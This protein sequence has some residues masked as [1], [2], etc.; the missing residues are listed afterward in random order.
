MRILMVNSHGDDTVVGGTEKGVDLLSSGLAARGHSVSLLAAFPGETTGKAMDTTVLHSADWRRS[1]RVRVQN[2]VGDWLSLPRAELSRAVALHAPDVVHTH[3]LPGIGG[4]IWETC[5]RQ[6]VPVVHTL[7]DYHLLCPRVTLMHRDGVTPCSPHPLLCGLRTQRLSRFSDAVSVLAG[8]S[9]HVVDAHAHLFPRAQRHV[10]RNPLAIPHWRT[11]QPPAERARTIGYVGN[12]D[13]IKGLGLLLEAVP[14]LAAL[15]LE[16]RIAGSGR[17]LEEVKATAAAQPSVHYHGVVGG[18]DKEDFFEACDIGIIPSVWAEPG[19][20]THTL[21]EWLSSGRPV[22]VSRRGGLGEVVDDFAGAI[23][24]E[25]TV[26]GIVAAVRHLTSGQ[27]WK[28]G[29]DRV[30][31][32]AADAH[33]RWVST[34][35]AIYLSVQAR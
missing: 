25:P 19:G 5:R 11:I 35:E 18:A 16:V 34:Y 33:D 21:I 8:V 17:L 29:V 20:P 31:P 3:N 32:I 23:A 14:A 2:H 9:T 27:A 10:V 15:G 28:Q 30:A 26:A 13:A 6:G 12:L 22:L 24:I 1:R 4:G 7:H